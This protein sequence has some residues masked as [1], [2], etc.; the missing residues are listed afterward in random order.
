MNILKKLFGGS[1]ILKPA[2]PDISQVPKNPIDDPDMIR[3]YDAYGREIFITRQQWYDSVLRGTIEKS[4]NDTEKLSSLIIQSLEDKFFEEMVNPAERLRQL[5]Q[6]EERGSVLLAIVYLKVGRLNDSEQV[7]QQYISKKG[8]SGVVLTNLA[9]VY[10]ER[11]E[12]EKTL[13]TLWH[14]LEVDPNQD[15]GLGWYEAIHRDKGDEPAGLEALRRIALLPGSW[16]AQLWLARAEL[17][18]LHL[19]SAMSLYRECLVR[20]G[21]PAPTDVLMQISGDLGNAGRLSHIFELVEPLYEPS[22]HGLQVGNNLVKAYITVGQL[23]EARKILEQLYLLK[24]PDWKDTLSYWDTEI[25]KAKIE[26]LNGNNIKEAEIEVGVMVDA[27]PVWLNY[28]SPAG[29]LFPVKTS[30]SLVVSF[31]GSTAEVPHASKHVEQQLSDPPGRMSRALP[32]F[33]AE[34]IEFR[35][36]ARSQTLIPWVTSSA[37]GFVLGA[38]TWEDAAAIKMSQDCEQ[39]A[40]YLVVTHLNNQSDEWAVDLRVLNTVDRQCIGRLSEPLSFV[41]PTPAVRRIADGLLELLKKHTNIQMN[42][43]A[44]KYLLPKTSYFPSYLLRLEQ[45]L[46]VRCAGIDNVSSGF[47]NGERE[48]ID[49]SL[50]QCLDAPTSV[51]TRLLFAQTVRA[52]KTARP[53]ILPE[54]VERIALLQKDHALPEPAHGVVQ[55]ILDKA[56][57]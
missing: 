14:A 11:G 15:N 55:E 18:S 44:E 5:E 21:N 41:D 35:S 2:T 8:E 9:K 24:R 46:A 7:L 1:K 31:L 26:K 33:L 34:Q 48:I 10:A 4:W 20:A 37:G 49:G 40:D 32:L 36:D 29:K 50:L 51:N 54:F 19:D 42:A 43:S 3:A 47:L 6:D 53:D 17:Q 45:L 16:R 39:K 28:D 23:D 22:V 30:D 57:A 38:L 52:M 12:S 13:E 25:A 56:L 27:G